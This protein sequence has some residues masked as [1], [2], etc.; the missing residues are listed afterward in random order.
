MAIDLFFRTED[1]RVEEVLDYLVES[2]QDRRIIDA[3]KG[4]SALILRGSRGVGKSF[5]MR[6]AQAEME[7]ELTAEK[8]LPV[9]VTFARA[10]LIATPTPERFL[11]WMTAKICNSV[12][13]AATKAGH[14]MPGGSAVEAISGKSSVGGSRLEQLEAELEDSWR[15]NSAASDVHSVPGPDTV[16]DAI[17]DFCNSSGIKRINLLVDE[18][19]HVFIPQQQ[20]Q[21]FTLMRDL[22]SPYLSVKAAVYPGATSFGDSFQP[23]HDATL[24]SVDRSVLSDSYAQNMR[25]LVLR[26]ERSLSKSL[27]QYGDVFDTLAYACTGNPRVLLKIV[28]RSTPFNRR[29]IQDSMR[30][31]FREEIWAEHSSLAERYP[32]HRALIDWGRRFVETELLPDLYA[33][34]LGRSS[35]TSSYVWIHR[36]APRTV[37]EA[38]RLLCYSGILQEGDSGIRAT[39]SELGSRYMVNLGC[40]IVLDAEPV[41]YGSALRKGL[42]VKRMIEYGANHPSYKPIDSLSLADIETTD[43]EALD[44][45][46]ETGVD[47]LDITGFQREKLSEL[48][49]TTIGKV[50]AAKEVDFQKAHYVGKVRSRQMR[51]AAV[52]AVL[53]YLSG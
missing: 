11:A 35:D 17:E 42:S 22:R 51:N 26:Q 21:F 29:N 43:N 2:P 10:S 52:T 36:D 34:N 4:R 25:D 37:H 5:L 28:S 9:Y 8:I 14:G 53:E 1:I 40:Q 24:A 44:A 38:L 23:T 41:T 18:A 50:L 47:Y 32:G 31:Y 15:C 49:L 16:R 3:L 7:L 27:K 12:V 45:R 20:R 33:R 13:R 6:A 19:A 39:R 46:L 30:E 48:G